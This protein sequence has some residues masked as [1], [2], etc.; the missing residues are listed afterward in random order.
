MTAGP[1]GQWLV[2]AA[3]DR[4]NSIFREKKPLNLVLAGA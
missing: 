4:W 2:A 1:A 3:R